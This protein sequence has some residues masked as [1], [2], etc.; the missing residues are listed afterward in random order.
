M[1]DKAFVALK[2][3]VG[4]LNERSVEYQITGGFAAKMYGSERELNDID[5]DI[6]DEGM[7]KILP[8]I[9]PHV[10]FGPTRYTDDKWDCLLVTLSY[11]GREIDIAGID[12]LRISNKERARWI[13]YPDYRFEV[14]DMSIAG[15]KVK[16]QHPTRLIEY[17]REL[18]GEHQQADIQTAEE[19]M[20]RKSR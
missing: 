16:V 14:V 4:I 7:N 18:D 15:I 19:Y 9:Q 10:I 13:T 5:I 12:T 8:M 2:W 1:E 11:H 3:I 20:V 6:R 17:K